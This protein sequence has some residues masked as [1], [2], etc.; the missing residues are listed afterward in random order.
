[1]S[2]SWHIFRHNT[3]LPVCLFSFKNFFLSFKAFGCFVSKVLADL[4]RVADSCKTQC[5]TSS[6]KV[7]SL[8][9]HFLFPETLLSKPFLV[10]LPSWH[11]VIFSQPHCFFFFSPS[12]LDLWR[13]Y[14]FCRQ[15]QRGQFWRMQSCYLR[16]EETHDLMKM[17]MRLE[18]YLCS[19]W[20]RG[21]CP[22]TMIPLHYC[23]V[24]LVTQI[25]KAHT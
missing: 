10:L 12:S 24:C 4:W 7:A 22:S 19:F 16:M 13:R 14:W 1:M 15:K 18:D 11:F 3:S 2:I 17:R 25:E 9:A 8:F 5:E 23:P 21:C 20:C 6:K